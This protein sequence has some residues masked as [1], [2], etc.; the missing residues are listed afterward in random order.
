MQINRYPNCDK[1]TGHKIGLKV[2]AIFALV[3]ALEFLILSAGA[4]AAEK[5]IRIAADKLMAAYLNNEVA[6]DARYKEKL[7]AV[8]GLVANVGKDKGDNYVAL[9]ALDI[10]GKIQCF[11]EKGDDNSLAQLG[12]GVQV[13]IIGRCEG[14]TKEDNILL[15]K[16]VL[17]GQPEKKQDA[18]VGYSNLGN[19]YYGLGDYQE[20][21]KDFN[22][23][24]E[25]D[26]KLAGAYWGRGKTYH[27]L[28]DYQQ[29]IKDFDRAIELNPKLGGAYW[30]RG[31]TYQEL[32]NQQ[33][34]KE[35]FK[36]AAK[37]PDEEPQGHC[38]E[39]RN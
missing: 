12:S 32:G 3:I 27:E 18:A 31:K 30:S 15:K 38:E 17:K 28:G 11:F 33:Q 5:P 21:I 16:C 13:T 9:E 25:L 14:K 10:I 2:G 23:A 8:T 37:L 7:L 36:T 29:A 24:I 6:A 34:A 19:N 26:P 20:A 35:D 39:Q 1:S 22:R 4:G